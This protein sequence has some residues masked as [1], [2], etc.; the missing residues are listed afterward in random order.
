MFRI[1]TTSAWIALLPIA[2]VGALFFSSSRGRAEASIAVIVHEQVPVDDL[3]LSELRQ[4][5][6]GKRQDWSRELPVTLLLPPRGT[7]ERRVLLDKIYQQRSEVQVQHYWINRLF[8]DE[9]QVGPK[10]TGSNEMSASLAR[11]IPGAIALV[12]ADRIP[13]GVKVLRIDGKK[14]GQAGYPLVASG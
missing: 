1:K 2:F 3:S 13:P 5:F 8:G 6:L 11:V 14:P 12:P 10:V 9:V 4:I 7:P